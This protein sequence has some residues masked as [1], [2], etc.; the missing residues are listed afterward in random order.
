MRNF[1]KFLTLVLA[2]MMVVSAM[3]VSTSAATFEDVT[4]EDEYLADAVDLLNYMG[5]AKGVSDTKFGTDELVTRQQFALFIYRMMKGG[6]DAPSTGNN[7]TKFTDLEDKTYFYA[8]SYAYSQGIVNGTSATTFSPKAPIKLQDAYTMVVRA[9]DW[10]G[11]EKLAY[12]FGYTD[13]AE[14]ENVALDKGLSSDLGYEDYL[15]RGDMAKILYNAFFAETGIPETTTVGTEVGGK[16][17]YETVEEYPTF[18]EKVFDV[19]EVVY[20]AVATPHYAM[21]GEATTQ[22]LGYDAIYFEMVEADATSEAPEYTYVSAE[23]LG[24]DPTHLDDYFLAHF[25]MYVTV[26]SEEGDIESVLFADSNATSKTVNKIDFAKVTSNK[27]ASYYDGT[28]TKLLSGKATADGEVFYFFNAPYSYAAPVYEVGATDAEKYDARQIENIEAISFS[29]ADEDKKEYSATVSTIVETAYDADGFYAN[30]AAALV[31]LFSQAYYGG[32]FEADLYDVDG[33]G[34]YDYIDYKPYTFFQLNDDEDYTIDDSTD[35]LVP[36]VYTY[37]AT[38]TGEKYEDEDFV[39][40]YYSVEDNMIHVAA[41]VKPTATTVKGIKTTDA[42]ITLANDEKVAVNK[43]WKYVTNYAPAD[44]A[45]DFDAQDEAFNEF[46]NLLDAGILDADEAN[47]YIY[48]GVVL[49]TDAVNA[50]ALTFSNN[51]LIPVEDEDVPGALATETSFNPTTGEKVTYLYAWVDGTLKYVP[52]DTEELYPA[53][54]EAEYLGKLCTYSVNADGV[55]TIKSLGYVEDEDG[56]YEGMEKDEAL[57]DDEDDADI[58]VYVDGLNDVAIEKIAGTRF[59]IGG[60]VVNLKDYTKIVVK[61]TNTSNDEVEYLVLGAADL[62]S[63]A[64]VTLDNVS[65]ILAN[66]TASKTREFLVVLYGEADDFDF[67]GTSTSSS[68]RIVAAS[69]PG[70]DGN[71]YYRNYYSVINPF[72]GMKESDIPGNKSAASST[73]LDS[74]I[75]V[76]NIALL[77]DGK[78]DEKND[79]ADGNLTDETELVWITDYS[80]SD[81]V[82]EVVA[83]SDDWHNAETADSTLYQVDDATVVTSVTYTNKSAALFTW[84]AVKLLDA[85]VL[86]S[87]ANSY[88]CYNDKIDDGKGGYKTGYAMYK[89]AYIETTEAKVEGELDT[90]DYVVILVHAYETEGVL[91]TNK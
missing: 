16:T 81:K 86:G 72:T 58:Q 17:Y 84:G 10:E 20:Q 54:N 90:V 33:D 38:V 7:T 18:C 62:T 91:K 30:E 77:K 79:E 12:P 36:V 55:Y 26:D 40:G 75:A 41:V 46:A 19:E 24:I 52:V 8:I 73:T 31:E 56:N 29:V 65:L 2:V 87:D 35:D 4:G 57:L 85:D 39:I 6:K 9:L 80:A 14:S 45:L 60:Y 32:L 13:I 70:M 34:I 48:N 23:D 68:Q 71:N 66:D 89:K 5:I 83:V 51:L 64:A 67:A 50:G 1:K 69:T 37:E 63:S 82:M 11:E 42:T 22:S 61:N 25:T 47:Y 44:V 74:P 78:I 53:L 76:G 27:Q 3:A 21:E 49:Y 15:T 88:K 43:A 59:D 28:D